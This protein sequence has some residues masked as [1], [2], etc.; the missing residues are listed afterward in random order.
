MPE[1]TNHAPVS[2]AMFSVAATHFTLA[3]LKAKLGIDLGDQEPNLLILVT[4]IAGYLTS[5]NS[6]APKA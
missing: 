4:G 3:L 6:V 2:V 5:A 1:V